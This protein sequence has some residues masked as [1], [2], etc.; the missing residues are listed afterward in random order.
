MGGA[1]MMVTVALA[2]LYMSTLGWTGNQSHSVIWPSLGIFA[3]GLIGEFGALHEEVESRGYFFTLLKQPYG[4]AWALFLSALLF[5]LGHIPFKGVD[6]MLIANFFGGIGFGYLYL[7]SGSLWVALMAHAAHN[8]ATDLFFT[9]TNN[10]VSVG[11]ALFHFNN[12]L[13][14][15]QRLPY[16]AILM[17]LMI[18]VAYV[19]Y[20]WGSR[21]F[22]PSPRLARRWNAAT[23]GGAEHLVGERP[24]VPA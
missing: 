12:K 7:K 16:D 14:L 23:N 2:W 3:I 21:F 19:G 18:A 17:L 22:A 10:G 15:A 6:W 4:V 11:I 8:L 5:M 13:T 9:G 20:G 24:V 1:A